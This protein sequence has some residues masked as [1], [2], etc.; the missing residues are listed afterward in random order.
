M[1]VGCWKQSRAVPRG[2]THGHDLPHSSCCQRPQPS[3]PSPLLFQD[4]G[5]QRGK[6]PGG[7]W[8]SLSQPCT[9]LPGQ[10]STEWSLSQSSTKPSILPKCHPHRSTGAEQ[11]V[12]PHGENE[13]HNG[14]LVYLWCDDL[15]VQ[16]LIKCHGSGVSKLFM[17]AFVCLKVYLVFC[18][19]SVQC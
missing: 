12:V 14:P 18:C 17:A 5:T 7:W 13:G 4:R 6:Q 19:F 10:Q 11:S 8:S 15:L 16:Q 9:L 2:N 3:A 1:R